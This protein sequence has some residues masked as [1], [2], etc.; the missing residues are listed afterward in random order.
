MYAANANTLTRNAVRADV[1]VLAQEAM[2]NPSEN[3]EHMC[4]TQ[5]RRKTACATSGVRKTSCSAKERQNTMQRYT[6]PNRE[7]H[8]TLHRQVGNWAQAIGQVGN[9]YGQFGN[10]AIRVSYLGSIEKG[11]V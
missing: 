6:A 11:D 10:W 7:A 2:R 9:W 4:N 1:L 8:E 5:V 3:E